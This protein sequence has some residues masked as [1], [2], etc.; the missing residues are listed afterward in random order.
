MQ[1][2][3]SNNYSINPGRFSIVLPVRNG[4]EYIKECINSIFAQTIHD[5]NIVVLDNASTDGTADWLRSLKDPR[6][7]IY[8]SAISLSIEQNWD[9]IKSIARNEWMI[10]IGHDDLMNPDYL[11]VMEALI[12]KH[13]KASLYQSHFS[14]I[15]EHGDVIRE[16]K[17]M[18]E[19][20][21][22]ADFFKETLE[23][24]GGFMMRS[25]DYDTVGGVPMYPNLFFSDYVLWMELS[26]IAYKATAS[27]NV[28]SYRVHSKNTTA[29][30]ADEKYHKAFELFVDY[31]YTLKS[32]DE[33]LNAAINTY[34][35]NLI[36]IY[37]KGLSH[38]LLR[39]PLQ[40]RNNLTVTKLAKKY[41]GFA[42]KLIDN[43]KFDPSAITS[44]RIARMID[45]NPVTRRLFLLFKKIYSAPIGKSI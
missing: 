5:F 12:Q 28:F 17:P 16:C 27:A 6:I 32:K 20:Q 18:Q 2:A 45:S 15:D 42:D 8:S 35:K 10:I 34:A 13:P 14:F 29:T 37:C 1:N 40:K 4:G 26:G 44:V 22:A 11:E 9:R 43:N 36:S 19:I 23:N 33:E 39:T 30:S 41:K 31:L 21:S 24:G 38:R 25:S 7:I 3:V